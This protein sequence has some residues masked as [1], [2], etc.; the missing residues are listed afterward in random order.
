MRGRAFRI[1]FPFIAAMLC[2]SGQARAQLAGSP[3]PCFG[4]DQLHTGRSANTGPVGGLV[5][6]TRQIGGIGVASPAVGSGRVY[7]VSGGLLVAMSPNGEQ[8]WS[9][10]CGS[11]GMSSPAIAADG[12][13]Y[14][15][16]TDGY[17]YAVGSGG[18]LVWKKSLQGASDCSPAIGSDGTIYVGGSAKKMLAF[19]RDGTQRFSYLAGGAISSSAAIGPDGTIYFGCDDGK[20]YALYSN[21]SLKWKFS[22]NPVGAIKSSPAVGSDGTVYVGSMAG[23]LHA[24]RST[25][26]QSW[27]FSATGAIASSSAI[28]PDGS[29]IF[30]SR[31]G[32]LYSVNPGGSQKWKLYVGSYVDSSPAVD[33]N[34]TAYFGSYG[35]SMYSVSATGSLLWSTPVGTGVISSPAIGDSG[36]LYVLSYDGVLCAFGSDT[37]PPPA[38]SVMDDGMYATLPTSLHASWSCADPESGISRYEYAIGT[39]PGAQD[40]LPYTDAGTAT[41]ITRS[42]LPLVNGAD[43]YISVR[44][45]NGAGM[46]GAVGASDGIRVD[47]T[48]PTTPL[49][50]D[51]GDWTGLANQLH[52]VFGSGDTET[53]INHY[54]Y[55]LG[56]AVGL[57]DVLDWTNSG[58]IKDRTIASLSLAHGVTY[59]VN[60]RAFNRAGLMSEGHSN[61]IKPDLSNP[62]VDSIMTR[63]TSTEIKAT[64]N[65]SDPESGVSE[66]QYVLLNSTEV[67][68]SPSWV[69]AVSGQEFTINGPLDWSKSYYIAARA[70]NGVGAWS[71]VKLSEAIRV[72]DTPPSTPVVIDDG[73]YQTNSTSLHA[74]WSSQD[75]E[76]GIK[77]YAYCV[78]TA[79]GSSDVIAWTTTTHDFASLTGLTLTNGAT[80][81]F[82]VRATNGAGLVS[83]NGSSDGIRIDT[84][85]PSTPVVTDDGDFTYSSDSLHASWIST[86]SESG[87]AEYF[88]C[89]GTAPGSADIVGWASSGTQS[90]TAISGLALQPAVRYYFT[91]KARNGAGLVSELG[92]SDGVEYRPGVTVWP[93]FR[94][95]AANTG[96]SVVSA[97]MTG[98]VR[99]QFQTQGYVESSAAIGGDGAAYVGSSDGK[100]YAL[101][102]SGGLRWTFQTGGC[103]DSSPAIG[104]YGDVYVGSYDGGLYCVGWNGVM[105]WRFATSGMVWSSP[106]LAEDGSIIFGCQNGHVYALKPDGTLK[107]SYNAG[108]PVWSSP[109]IAPD[110]TVYFGCG[111]GK[112]YALTAGGS[113]KWAYLT[114][115]AIDSSPAVDANGVIYI[116]SGD[117]SFY[118]IRPDGTKKWSKY[119]GLVA[120]SSPAIASDG[121]IYFGV[122]VVGGSGAFYALSTNG[123]TLW[124]MTLPGAVRS[125]PALANDGTVYFGCADGTMYAVGHTGMVI[126]QRKMPESMMASP[127]LGPDGSVVVGSDDGHVY[128]FRDASAGDTTPPTTPV[129]TIDHEVLT[130]G[131]TLNCSWSASDPESGIQYY[132][133]AVGTQPGYDDAAA[134]TNTGTATSVSLQN[135][136][137]EPGRP[138]YV[139]VTATNWA[140]LKSAA[141][142][143]KGFIVISTAANN[144]IGW[145]KQRIDGAAM[146]LQGKIVTA[147]FD[148]CVYIEEL[149][150]ASGIRC[151]INGSSLKPGAIVDVTGSMGTRYGERVIN[152][153]VLTDTGLRA[154]VKPFYMPG[155]FSTRPGINPTGLLVR[156]FGRVTR[157]GEG[158][159][160]ISDG[161]Y[162]MSPRGAMGI[163]VRTNTTSI[164]P[165]GTYIT[166]TGIASCELSNSRMATVVRSVADSSPMAAVAAEK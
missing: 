74:S 113:L 163:E 149:N 123:D 19:N 110:G 91:V 76:T 103:I 105:K 64:V 41:E 95:N 46:V 132:S 99:W 68:A 137:L 153:P 70:K 73:I 94:C 134:W 106:N 161:T 121:T 115:S 107:W 125:S 72:D 131:M 114:G 92:S 89:V 79:S 8:L 16:S 129:V 2:W 119:I 17:L 56:T 81:Y 35:G 21:G 122:G 52:V 28:A 116:G 1:M 5:A 80:Y 148:D 151:T 10:T 24:I 13:V 77:E 54:E 139:S 45:T 133:Y 138:Y 12:T 155:D 127:A 147:V 157:S 83:A 55:S 33:S 112:L 62:S 11:T 26:T 18:S 135:L 30:G 27:R 42:D 85:P 102:A 34:G 71:N 96:A 84:T 150:R 98:S 9:F 104:P 36:T 3:W 50:I 165:V 44:A 109:A 136:Q 39:S 14:I 60:V 142:V 15:A 29:I 61:G 108:A 63:A 31:D 111:D 145:A 57:V 154:E 48:P 47:F 78:G 38:P 130:P 40:L 69:P 166:V 126:W 143:S 90:W 141:G 58:T 82:T 140:S 101:N 66:T 160:V 158:W 7:V 32:S 159:Y 86:D 88:F 53:G 43:Y 22:V 117:A 65:A 20:L 51:D 67:P 49:V 152:S 156:V 144:A 128:S 75:A 93:K 162:V 146:H 97:S 164:M 4:H 25:G 87:L 124:H 37:T 120:D 118:A 100:L 6:W 23:Y 59:F